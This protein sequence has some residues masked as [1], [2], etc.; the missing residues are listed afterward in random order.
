MKSKAPLS[1]LQLALAVGLVAGSTAVASRSLAFSSMLGNHVH[2]RITQSCLERRGFASTVVGRAAADVGGS[3]D[4]DQPDSITGDFSVESYHCCRGAVATTEGVLARESFR[5]FAATCATTRARTARIVKTLRGHA[6]EYVAVQEARAD[7]GFA[8]HAIQD[9]YAHTNVID[10]GF[11]HAFRSMAIGAAHPEASRVAGLKVC[12]YVGLLDGSPAGDLYP[13]DGCSK[14]DNTGQYPEATRTLH[15]RSK[16]AV[17]MGEA[18]AA[19]D[20]YLGLLKGKLRRDEWDALRGLAI[21]SS[22]PTV[23]RGRGVAQAATA[24]QPTNPLDALGQLFGAE[25]AQQAQ[26]Q[27]RRPHHTVTPGFAG[28]VN[29]DTRGQ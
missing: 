5:V 25:P 6:T 14:D 13:H 1:R 11:E 3:V 2:D 19:T 9:S 17:A 15:G 7:L 26:P 22:P 12:G 16:L 29:Q 10:E 20:E 28:T 18:A 4:V 24:A 21:T 8:L 23:P 27:P